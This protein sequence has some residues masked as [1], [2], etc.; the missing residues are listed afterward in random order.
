MKRKS[1]IALMLVLLMLFQLP[2]GNL[3]EAYAKIKVGTAVTLTQPEQILETITYNGITIEAAYTNGAYSGSDP[4]YSCAAFV[5]K[6]YSTVYGI[7]VYN[8]I[9]K[10][11]VPLV[12]QNIGSFS[13]TDQPQKGDIVRDNSRTHWA[14]VSSVANDVI[15]VIQQ[16]YRSGNTAWINCTIDRGDTGYSYFTYSGRIEDSSGSAGNTELPGNTQPIDYSGVSAAGS[17]PATAVVSTISEGTYRLVQASDST[18]LDALG[19]ADSWGVSTNSYLVTDS[20]KISIV[21]FGDM[22]YSLQFLSNQRFLSTADLKQM[23]TSEALEQKFIF[24]LRDNGY[25]TISPA[26]DRTKVITYV[27]ASAQNSQQCLVLEDYRGALEQCWYL[28]PEAPSVIPLA[29]KTTVNKKT[30]YRGNQDY[31]I[32]L[33]QLKKNSMV[34]FSSG[35]PAVAEVSSTGLVSPKSVGKTSIAVQV[36]QDS[37]VIQLQVDITVKAPYLKITTSGKKLSVGDS[38]DLKIKKY[39]TKSAVSL[40]VSDRTIAEIDSKNNKLIAKK[41]GTV[42]VIAKTKDGLS[43]KIVVTI[44]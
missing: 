24:L 13:L 5:K 36:L 33:N 30:L 42:T 25:Y 26:Q 27:R 8:L 9:S 43:A 17:T 20:Q 18:F 37:Q 3:P 44:V 14:I 35:N 12:Y 32:T 41:C 1:R 15:T 7:G 4:V 22:E 34:T 31:A 23:I 6:F 29:P 21:D 40:Q 28:G 38:V 11:S 2:Y 10:E 19:E 39:G 16:N